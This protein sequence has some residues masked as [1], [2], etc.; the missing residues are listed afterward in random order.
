[1]LRGASPWCATNAAAWNQDAQGVYSGGLTW[2]NCDMAT[3]GADSGPR[4]DLHAHDVSR[5]KESCVGAWTSGKCSHGC[6]EGWGTKTR[7]Y[8]HTRA[9]QPGGVACAHAD[10]DSESIACIVGPCAPA[11][12]GSKSRASACEICLAC[13][14]KARSGF[15]GSFMGGKDS[16]EMVT[17]LLVE[18]AKSATCK[19]CGGAAAA[20]LP[21]AAPPPTPAPTPP[22]AATPPPPHFGIVASSMQCELGS[23]WGH[24]TGLGILLTGAAKVCT[25]CPAGKWAASKHACRACPAGRF[26]ARA[27]GSVGLTN[28]CIAL[29]VTQHVMQTRTL[30]EEGCKQWEYAVCPEW[31]SCKA[32]PDIAE[33]NRLDSVCPVTKHP[34]APTHWLPC[35]LCPAQ[36]IASADGKKCA[37]EQLN[38]L[39]TTNP[40]GI[41]GFPVATPPSRPRPPPSRPPPATAAPPPSPSIIRQIQNA[42][43]KHPEGAGGAGLAPTAHGHSSGSYAATDDGS[44]VLKAT[45]SVFISSVFLVMLVVVLA[46]FTAARRRFRDWEHIRSRELAASTYILDAHAVY[47]GAAAHSWTGSTGG[48][49]GG[50]GGAGGAFAYELQQPTTPVWARSTGAA[51]TPSCGRP[52]ATSP[53][54]D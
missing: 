32:A 12:A 49:G 35:E 15:V 48:G 8:H 51:A 20:Q 7:V 33:C 21:A 54:F 41:N 44:V 17:Q 47:A 30:G 10:G 28:R 5:A 25:K 18:C 14:A 50:G 26:S 16:P 29:R 36:W 6:D 43:D 34:I 22:A 42:V 53:P 46:S 52:R 23:V 13:K 2:G 1:M 9:A 27:G 4:G 38:M 24:P 39:P 19:Q 31:Q 45:Q 37:P 3:C 11:N 40:N